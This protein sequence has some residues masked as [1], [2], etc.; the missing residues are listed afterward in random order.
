[1]N[2]DTLNT[3]GRI[4]VQLALAA[5]PIASIP[6]FAWMISLG[7][8][9]LQRA[10]WL[11][12]LIIPILLLSIISLVISIFVSLPFIARKR[13]RRLLLFSGLSL[14]LGFAAFCWLVSSMKKRVAGGMLGQLLAFSAF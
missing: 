2:R 13:W 10:D 4:L 7:P 11:A 6:M 12:A 8:G 14:G 5:M 9:S 3:I 1:M